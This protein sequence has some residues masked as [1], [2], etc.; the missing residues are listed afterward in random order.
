MHVYTRR[1]LLLDATSLAVKAVL[2]Y[3]ALLAQKLHCLAENC[4]G[5][6]PWREGMLDIH[7]ISTGRGSCALLVCPD[8]TT[9]MIDAGSLITHLDMARDKYLIDPKPNA[10]RRPGEWIARYAKRCL[11]ESGREQL[12]YFLLTH[13]HVDHFGEIAPGNETISPRS[14]FGPYQLGG[15]TD[16]AEVIPIGRIIDRGYP[17]YNY[18]LPLNDPQQKNYQSFLRSYIDRGGRV[19]RII[20]GGRNQISLTQ[21]AQKFPT[22]SIR[23]LAANGRVWTGVGSKTRDHFPPLNTLAIKDYPSENKCSLAIR[24]NYGRFS[25]FSAG[26]MDHEVE[27]GHLPWGDIE[28]LVAK[29]SGP[30]Q[31]AVADHHGYADA[32]GPGWVRALRPQAFIINAWDSAHPSIPVLDNML[33]MDLYPTPRLIFSTAMKPE[34]VIATRRVAEMMSQN[35]HVIC[36]V[37]PGGGSYQIFVKDSSEESGKI[38]GSFGPFYC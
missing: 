9:L 6:T 31:I 37:A 17:D 24:L 25:Y 22:V 30:V 4:D 32:C 19:E 8:G 2:S 20:P 7:H 11:A 36:R 33:S 16:V 23:N 10:S 12:D 14:Q 35:G 21:N 27:Y 29:A 15:L 5:L 18:P 13:F 34:N 3:P 28:S 38:V 26:D 1:R